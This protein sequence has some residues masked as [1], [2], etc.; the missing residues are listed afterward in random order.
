[1]DQ[2][3]YDIPGSEQQLGGLGRSKVYELIQTGELRVV[4]IG[5]RTFISR[6]ELEAFIARQA[7]E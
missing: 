6:A 3:L 7:G 5:R 1:M 4:K 2:L